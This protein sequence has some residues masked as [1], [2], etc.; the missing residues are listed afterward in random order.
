MQDA[1]HD[2]WTWYMLIRWG[3]SIILDVWF[4]GPS[5]LTHLWLRLLILG[6]GHDAKRRGIYLVTLDNCQERWWQ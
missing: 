3:I 5:D 4:S 6:R 1:Q 2:A